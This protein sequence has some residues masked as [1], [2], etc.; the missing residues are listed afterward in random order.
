[1]PELVERARALVVDDRRAILGI[2]GPPGAGKSTLVEDLLA[3]LRDGSTDD[4]VA[5]VPMDG[6]HL[7]D[8]QL[9]TLG[10]LDRKGAPETFDSAGFVAALE[11]LLTHTDEVVYLPGFERETE[12]PIAA[13]I[14]VSPATRL[15]VTEGNYLL[16]TEGAWPQVR[17]RLAEV[18]YCELDEELRRS[19]LTARHIRSGK[20][21]DDARRWVLGTD[22]ANAERVALTRASADL[23]IAAGC[24]PPAGG[25]G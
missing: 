3:R 12:Q 19:R 15:V 11:R 18:W 23:V 20:Q 9:R 25:S 4:W 22:Q 7:A 1:M 24:L 5:H 14:A 10:L 13:S 17:P 21:P 2:T 16:L 6:F 8:V